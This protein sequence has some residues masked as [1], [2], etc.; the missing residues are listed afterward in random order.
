MILNYLGLRELQEL[1]G[2]DLLER[3]E[4]LLP[5]LDPDGG[6]PT[7]IYRKTNLAKILSSFLTTERLRDKKFLQTLFDSFPE[8]VLSELCHKLGISAGGK[9]FGELVNRLVKRGGKRDFIETFVTWAE[10]PRTLIAERPASSP[11]SEEAFL[12]VVPYKVLKDFQFPV[13]FE[14]YSELQIPLSRFIIQMPTGSGKTRT[15]ME[16]ITQFFCESDEPR[17]CIWLAN[18]EELCEQAVE[19]F[20]EV[21]AHV[22]RARLLVYRLWGSNSG[23]PQKAD[24]HAFV[25]AG[26]EKMHQMIKKNPNRIGSVKKHIRLVLVDE[27]HHA[28]APTYKTTINRLIGGNSNLIGLTATPGRSACDLKK[29]QELS[30]FFFGRIIGIQCPDDTSV[31][32]LLREKDIL[33]SVVFEELRTNRSYS[34]TGKEIRYIEE[35][36]SLP[37]GFLRK[38]GSDDIRNI[39][40]VKK[41]R[42]ELGENRKALFFGCSV[43]HSKFICSIMKFLGIETV[44]IDGSTDRKVRS[45]AI[46]DFREGNFCSSYA[47]SEFFRL[48]L[49]HQERI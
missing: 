6:D 14:A 16:I 18:T 39:E 49:M 22:G 42:K 13:F 8:E 36:R 45:K 4:T 9:E 44:H 11:D 3:L 20:K 19:C 35:K 33:S 25:V 43:D 28:I 21:W 27:A 31:I 37:V 23:F 38:I 26:F 29:N 41:L 10:L 15:S 32:E 12:P 30:D 34:L 2:P 40:I 48:D 47:I 24:E 5:V 17:I 7:V 1:I 46:R